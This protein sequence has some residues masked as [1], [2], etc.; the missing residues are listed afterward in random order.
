MTLRALLT[1][2][3]RRSIAHVAAARRLVEADPARVEE[4]VALARD[5]DWLVT[6]RALDLVEK[7]AHAHPEWVAPYK[8]LF[9]GPLAEHDAWEIRLQI[10]RALPLFRWTPRQRARAVAILERDV[11]HPQLF[12]RAWA[13][14]SLARFAESLPALRPVVRR[15]L[16]AFERSGRKALLSRARQIRARLAGSTP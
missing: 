4:L 13:L 7:L 2:G 9:I 8:R 3:D 5:P 16:A 10:V 12:V 6:L 14:D 15:H 11:A 1:G